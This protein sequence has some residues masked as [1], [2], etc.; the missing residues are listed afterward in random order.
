MLVIKID[1]HTLYQTL[2]EVDHT[3]S[4]DHFKQSNQSAEI[5][6]QILADDSITDIECHIDFEGITVE[7]YEFSDMAHLIYM[8]YYQM[9]CTE[10]SDGIDYCFYIDSNTTIGDLRDESAE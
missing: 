7:M 8:W 2:N 4:T 9:K 10:Y 1:K 6:S 3:V 5:W